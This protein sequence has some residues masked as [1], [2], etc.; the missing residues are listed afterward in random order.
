MSHSIKKKFFFFNVTQH[1]KR[2]LVT[3]EL[4][5]LETGINEITTV[6]YRMH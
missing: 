5:A 6:T 4:T 1:F 3:P 2:I